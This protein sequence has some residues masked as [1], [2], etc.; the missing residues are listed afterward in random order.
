ML[1]CNGSHRKL[2]WVLRDETNL[3]SVPCQAITARFP[4]QLSQGFPNSALLELGA[5]P[6]P[7][8]GMSYRMCAAALASTQ[9]MPVAT[10]TSPPVMIRKNVSRHCQGSLEDT[11]SSPKEMM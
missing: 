6:S 9:H 8:V 2:I 4:Q 11:K 7:D 5:L 3:S 10:L 1:I